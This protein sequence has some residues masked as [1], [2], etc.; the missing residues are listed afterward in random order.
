MIVPPRRSRITTQENSG[1]CKTN[2]QRIALL[3]WPG[4]VVVRHGQNQR[5]RMVD[6]KNIEGQLFWVLGR[7]LDP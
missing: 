2:G 4:M 3:W 7:G 1:L 6:V 5:D